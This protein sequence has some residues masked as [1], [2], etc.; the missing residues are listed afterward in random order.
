MTFTL[1]KTESSGK[2]SWRFKFTK[3]E[4]KLS[5]EPGYVVLLYPFCDIKA[6]RVFEQWQSYCDY[7]S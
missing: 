3:V 5:T 2:E 7:S 1:L 6:C 4:L